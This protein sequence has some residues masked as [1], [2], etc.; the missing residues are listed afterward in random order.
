M[1]RPGPAKQM[2]GVRLSAPGLAWLDEMA[3]E[4]GVDRSAVIRLCLL[5]AQ[6][7]MP[8]GWQR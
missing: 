1:P 7:H 5:Y 3:A 8:R 4:R 6:Q 2:V